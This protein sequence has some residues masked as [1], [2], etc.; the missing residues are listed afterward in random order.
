M[1]CLKYDLEK[2][3]KNK[4]FAIG[5][6]GAIKS[7]IILPSLTFTPSVFQCFYLFDNHF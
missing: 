3:V 6:M 4:S 1:L 5:S 7:K 2:Y